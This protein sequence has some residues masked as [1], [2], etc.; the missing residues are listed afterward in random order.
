MSVFDDWP[1]DRDSG[2]AVHD[3][4]IDHQTAQS[5]GGTQ[6][7]HGQG[8]RGLADPVHDSCPWA[9]LAQWTIGEHNA[10][11]IPRNGCSDDQWIRQTVTHQHHRPFHASDVGHQSGEFSIERARV[12]PEQR[13]T[14]GVH[15]VRLQAL[16]HVSP[17]RRMEGRAADTNDGRHGG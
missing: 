15:A 12:G 5:D 1:T 9:G 17:H 14:L 10:R 6:P 16:F 11:D 4:G 3:V 2:V 8:P 7:R 13:P